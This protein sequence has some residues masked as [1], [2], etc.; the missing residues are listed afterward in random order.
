MICTLFFS[1]VLSLWRLFGKTAHLRRFAFI[2]HVICMYI[3][4]WDFIILHTDQ[5]SITKTCKNELE[6]YLPRI[7]FISEIIKGP[8][9]LW[10]KP[11]ELEGQY[12]GCWGP[13]SSHRQ[14]MT[15]HDE[16][17]CWLYLYRCMM[18]VKQVLT[19]SSMRKTFNHLCHLSID[20]RIWWLYRAT[21]VE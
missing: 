11:G 15:S 16:P 21:L 19:A 6:N 13:G 17:W 9:P 5:P 20:N 4:W 8:A 18:K 1:E 3:L 14:D 7:S 10:L 2:I 12:R